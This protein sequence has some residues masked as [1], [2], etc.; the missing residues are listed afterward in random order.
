MFRA[1]LCPSSGQQDRVLLHMVFCTGCVGC[2]EKYLHTVHT[3]YD[4][5]R[6]NHS[7]QN[8]CR[9]PYAVINGLVLLMMG[10]ILPETCSD[11]S[12]IINIGLVASCWFISL[13]PS[14]HDSRSQE[15]KTNTYLILST[16]YFGIE[17]STVREILEIS[18]E[19]TKFYTNQYSKPNG[20][21]NYDKNNNT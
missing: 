19:N 1:T 10:I 16:R 17:L 18:T 3:A 4:P 21:M 9:K 13:H 8:Q 20:P 12:L 11:R 15:P 7:Q 6:H 2:V 14:F 5:A